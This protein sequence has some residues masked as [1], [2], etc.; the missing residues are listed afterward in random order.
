[1]NFQK[2]SFFTIINQG[3]EAYRLTLGKNATKLNPGVAWNIPLIHQIAKLDMR[4]GPINIYELEAF[5]KDN[6]PVKIGGS[7]F[8]QITDSYKACFNVQNHLTS[9]KDIGT[10]GLRSVIGL[11][12]YDDIIS[13]RNQINN[14]LVK[15]IGNLSMQWGIHCTKFEIQTFKPSNRDIERQLEMQME[16]ERNRRKQLLDTEASINIAEGLKKTAILKSEGILQAE[17]NKADAYNYTMEKQTSALRYQIEDISKVLNNDMKATVE[18]LIR[19]KQIEQLT[20]IANGNNNSTY[21]LNSSHV[22]NNNIE[23]IIPIINETKKII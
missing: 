3:F 18:Y 4:E 7:L 13:D 22:N 2:R 8:Y 17:R 21:F 23:N 11:F 9:V 5:T 16:A 14:K 10:S 12:D 15:V 1:M 19:L 6:V 20:A